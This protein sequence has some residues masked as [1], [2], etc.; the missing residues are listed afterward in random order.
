MCYC[1]SSLSTDV[2]DS[3]R[4][5]LPLKN[6]YQETRF[7][8]SSLDA[9]DK[10][11]IEVLRSVGGVEVGLA[12]LKKEQH[13]CSECAIPCHRKQ[14]RQITVERMI[15]EQTTSSKDLGCNSDCEIIGDLDAKLTGKKT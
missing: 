5:C 3:K 1:S 14:L 2:E 13:L 12:V 6:N 7:S 15:F 8:F 4:V 9:M 11:F 10:T